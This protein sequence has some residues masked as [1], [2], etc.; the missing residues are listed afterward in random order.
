MFASVV[1][2]GLVRCPWSRCPSS[3]LPS[4]LG[5]SGGLPGRMASGC[6]L[7][8]SSSDSFPPSVLRFPGC[9]IASNRA[10][11]AASGQIYGQGAKTRFRAFWRFVVPG[12]QL[13][14][15]HP[16]RSASA[17]GFL[18]SAAGFPS[19]VLPQFASIGAGVRRC[20]PGFP[21][22]VR[23]SSGLPSSVRRSAGYPQTFRRWSGCR[24][25]LAAL[26]GLTYCGGRLSRCRMRSTY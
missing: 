7:P 17:V 5:A 21:D 16:V 23:R 3:A 14:S 11:L 2:P 6:R 13:A 15:W 22:P 10:T 12:P 1:L 24:D 18:I 9:L 26:H 25:D 20:L 19:S 4:V 8:V